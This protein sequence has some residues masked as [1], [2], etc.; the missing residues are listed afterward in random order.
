MRGISWFWCIGGSEAK[1]RA[2]LRRPNDQATC[3]RSHLSASPVRSL[4]H[5]AMRPVVHHLPAELPQPCSHDGR[6]WR[7]FF[8]Q[9]V[10]RQ[11]SWPSKINLDGSAATHRA[12]L[13]LRRQ[14]PRWQSVVIRSRRYLNNIAEQDHRAIKRRCASMLGLKS[15]RTASITLAGVEL[16]HRIRKQQFS[17][18]GESQQS[19]LKHLCSTKQTLRS[20]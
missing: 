17:I 1:F 12:L 3:A 8:R 9:A 13:F 19:S 2:P 14:D 7:K 6:A 4:R 10:A 15:Y 16:A 5:R 20:R 18:A 11:G